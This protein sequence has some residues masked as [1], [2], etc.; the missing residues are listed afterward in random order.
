[1][2]TENLLVEIGT[3]EL[4]P[5]A[6]RKLA[7]SFAENT[8]QELEALELEH[9]G[10]SW[11][12]SPRRLGVKVKALQTKQ[13]DKVVEK[14][15]P[16]IKAAFDADGNATKAALGWA[17]GCGIDIA[18]AERL[19]TE[20]GV[21]LLHKAKVEGQQTLALLNDVINKALAKLPIPKPM[22]WGANKTQF[23]RPVHTVAALLGDQQV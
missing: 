19:E 21:W 3:E 15:G 6:L 11:Y 18:D 14:R 1:M 4:P 12:A 17:R 2:S 10:V 8:Q 7:E 20:K 16:A 13:A 23:I 9:Q 5:K 22:R